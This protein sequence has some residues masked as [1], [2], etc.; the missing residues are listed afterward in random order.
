MLTRSSK[1]HANHPCGGGGVQ[2]RASCIVVARSL[3]KSDMSLQ[4]IS[5]AVLLLLPVFCA[6]ASC[7]GEPTALKQSHPSSGRRGWGSLT[8]HYSLPARHRY[9]DG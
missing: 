4:R 9:G 5:V 8:V 2:S 7:Q 3:R 1:F 6:L